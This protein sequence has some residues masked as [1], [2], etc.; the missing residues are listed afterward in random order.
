MLTSTMQNS[1]E[2]RHASPW[3]FSVRSLIFAT[4]YI[5]FILAWM[6]WFWTDYG[7]MTF[8]P[9]FYGIC[10]IVVLL[11][12][13]FE[14]R[15]ESGCPSA[16]NLIAVAWFITAGNVFYGIELAFGA[17]SADNP[18]TLA[19][20]LQDGVHS[21]IVSAITLPLFFTVPGLYTLISRYRSR[22]QPITCAIYC[23]LALTFVDAS[24][25]VTFVSLTCGTWGLLPLFARSLGR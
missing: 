23:T 7:V 9:G 18:D 4:A 17:V 25:F 6:R 10:S 21:A 1:T 15:N 13:L 22:P 20:I 12:A 8:Y 24:L 3:Q 5:S 14:L 19:R 16:W 11:F 2:T